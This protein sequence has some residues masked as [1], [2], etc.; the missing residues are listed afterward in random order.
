MSDKLIIALSQRGVFSWQEFKSLLEDIFEDI[1]YSENQI[2]PS[3]ALKILEGLAFISS[4]FNKGS[5]VLNVCPRTLVRLPSNPLQ[6]ILVGHRTADTQVLLKNICETLGAELKT[7]N[8]DLEFVPDRLMI[9]VNEASD[10]LKIAEEIE[11]HYH[12]DPASWR[13][14]QF[15][16][17]LSDYV[18]TLKWEKR[19]PYNWDR[20]DFDSNSLYFVPPNSLF[21]SNNSLLIQLRNP[22]YGR[23]EFYLYRENPNPE[24]CKVDRDWGRYIILSAANKNLILYSKSGN[25]AVPK[26]SLLPSIFAIGLSM[27]SGFPPSEKFLDNKSFLVYHNIPVTFGKLVAEKL[28]Q[29]L[30]L[31]NAF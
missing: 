24:I 25:L 12:S 7:E 31:H 9:S 19:D 17:T 5:G 6:A 21:Q 14:L 26:Q 30:V 8:N 15:A 2:K 20:A 27:C 4:N 28:G 10:F 16:G 3:H 1:F 18:G 29:E 11:A 22:D 13:I 23:H